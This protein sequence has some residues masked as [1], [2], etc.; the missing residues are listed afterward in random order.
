MLKIITVAAIVSMIIGMIKDGPATGWI[1]GSTIV[2]AVVIIVAVTAGNNYMKEK[3][4]EKLNKKIDDKEVEVAFS[5]LSIGY[6]E[7][8]DCSNVNL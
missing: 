1:E 7:W 4:F 8:R 2:I 3:Q 5:N 6:K